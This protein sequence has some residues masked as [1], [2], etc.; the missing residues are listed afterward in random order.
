ML[1][2]TFINQQMPPNPNVTQAI[3]ETVPLDQPHPLP[4]PFNQRAFCRYMPIEKR[5]DA[6]RIL[7][8]DNLLRDENDLSEL[9]KQELGKNAASQLNRER[10]I[11]LMAMENINNNIVRLV[12][13]PETKTVHLSEA[14]QATE[15]FKPQ[16]IVMSGTLRDFDFYKPEYIENF[17]TFIHL[18]PVPVLGIC[19][20]HQLI[21]H[22]YGARIIT[23]D[24]LEPH[25]KRENRL[26]EYQYRFIRI[27]EP[28]D[29]IFQDIHDEESG[30]WQDY[31]KE[32]G[33]LRVWQNHGLQLDRVPEGFE[34]L[35]TAYLCKNQMMVK[36]SDGQLIYTV[37][38]HL[39]KS[40]E[41]WNKNRTRWEHPNESRDGRIIFENFLRLSL[42][43]V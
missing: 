20:A 1:E 10:F 41:D 16:A 34:L 24:N 12:K 4:F 37:Q 14:P 42:E 40:F 27:T 9:G 26:N 28:N 21:G 5:I 39:E 31:T 8:V 22:C 13:R 35:A 23:L 15:E 32:A 6:I 33:I 25:Q 18:T 17:K 38:Y 36:R 30:I 11:A 3:E 19:G 2:Q 7:V 43:H 29:P